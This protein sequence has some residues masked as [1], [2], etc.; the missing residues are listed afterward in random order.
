MKIALLLI[1]FI[2][3][4]IPLFSQNRIS[5][6][7]AIDDFAQ[8]ITSNISENRRIAVIALE[9][10]SNEMMIYFIDNMVSSL[11]EK[12]RNIE[13]YERLRIEH[14][15]REQN[16]NTTGYVSEET[17]QRIGQIVGVNTVIYG[18]II[19]RNN[20]ND[21]QITITA[22]DVETARILSQKVYDLR[23]DSRLRS[24]L[25]INW[26]EIHDDPHFWSAGAFIGTSFSEPWVI[27][28]INGTLAPFRYSFLE[29]GLDLGLVSGTP[30]IENYYSLYP[31][32]NYAVFLPLSKV[33]LHA[34]I[35]IGYM[36]G[37]R[38][39]PDYIDPIRIFAANVKIGLNFANGFDVSYTLRTNIQ[40]VNNKFSI[41]YSYRFNRK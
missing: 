2:T 38:T 11:L 26:I 5:V 16:F 20:R 1:I 24:L 36:I 8:N 4:S 3:S 30:D 37:E 29:I 22:A 15:L 33:N 32:A 31:Y 6:D 34:G 10:N 25:G 18:S 21:Y 9:T 35:G 40:S 23:T 7:T 27:G 39:F 17:A 12:D 13:V 28:S 41:G 19:I 14:P